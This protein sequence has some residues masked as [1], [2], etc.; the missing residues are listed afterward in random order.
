MYEILYEKIFSLYIKWFLYVGVG[1]ESHHRH[2]K[3]TPCVSRGFQFFSLLSRTFLTLFS[4][5]CM[6][7]HTKVCPIK[8]HFL[9]KTLYE[10]LHEILYNK[11]P[12]LY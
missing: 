8:H 4:F 2:Q 1:F 6:P 9:Y 10:F 11:T 12:T 3:K 7:T 5:L